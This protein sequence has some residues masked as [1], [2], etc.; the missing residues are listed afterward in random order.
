MGRHAAAFRWLSELTYVR[1]PKSLRDVP[2]HL[3]DG[4][5]NLLLRSPKLYRLI[6]RYDQTFRK[7]N[8][9][10]ADVFF[11]EKILEML[12]T[13]PTLEDKYRSYYSYNLQ[14]LYLQ[15]YE[16]YFVLRQT[17]L[18]TLYTQLLILFDLLDYLENGRVSDE[19]RQSEVLMLLEIGCR[20]NPKMTENLFWVI[21]NDF[22]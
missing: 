1:N 19:E 17:L 18:A 7:M 11:H 10:E 14:Q 13:D 6:R 16:T 21:R 5:G 22:L 20:H 15:A 12:A 9:R 3:L 2:P 8:V 4:D